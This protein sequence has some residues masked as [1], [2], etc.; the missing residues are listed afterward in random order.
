MQDQ[1]DLMP[2]L[3]EYYSMQKG[4]WFQLLQGIFPPKSLRRIALID[5][6]ANSIGFTRNEV[7]GLLLQISIFGRSS[8][9]PQEL[10]SKIMEFVLQTLNSEK[11]QVQL[12]VIASKGRT[13]TAAHEIQKAIALYRDAASAWWAVFRSS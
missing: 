3:V 13:E 11:S 6:I 1:V 9:D 8:K 10:D 5:G 4:N 2:S 7:F 12:S